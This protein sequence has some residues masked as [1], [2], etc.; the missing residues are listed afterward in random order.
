MTATVV[1]CPSCSESIEVPQIERAVTL[2]AG[3]RLANYEIIRRLGE[4]GM[5]EVFLARQ[6]GL[7]RDVALKTL[8]PRFISIRV[9]WTDL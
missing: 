5:G 6:S 3:S 4:G 7:N 2:Q 9:R 1:E 8:S